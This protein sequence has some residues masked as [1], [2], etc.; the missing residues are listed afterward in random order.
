MREPNFEKE[1]RQQVDNLLGRAW[2]SQTGAGVGRSSSV[3]QFLYSAPQRLKPA[4][5][6]RYLRCVLIRGASK[7]WLVSE[8]F[9]RIQQYRDW[10]FIDQ[11]HLHH[12]LKPSGRSGRPTNATVSGDAN[13][14]GNT[15]ND[16]LPKYGRNALLGPDYAT[17]DLRVARKMNLG[18]RYHLEL[19]GEAFNVVNRD[20]RR[21]G[22]SDNGFYNSAGQFVKYTQQAG[23]AYYPAYFQQPTNFMKPTS[24][25]AP[26]QLQLS[27]RLNF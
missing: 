5:I 22:L 13:Q 18:G 1:Q 20:N 8:Y 27:M 23:A 26:R 7:S 9:C 3:W 15:S 12:L 2:E 21:L 10:T 19:T 25:F 16:R 24:S 4:L 17:I 11:L 6:L 14:D